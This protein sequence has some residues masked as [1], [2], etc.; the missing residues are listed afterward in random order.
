MGRWKERVAVNITCQCATAGEEV[1][2][3]NPLCQSQL[4][5]H[6]SAPRLTRADTKKWLRST[7]LAS[8][9][10]RFTSAPSST[11]EWHL[12]YHAPACH[13]INCRAAECKL[14]STKSWTGVVRTT[15]ASMVWRQPF[16]LHPFRKYVP[17]PHRD[18]FSVNMS[19]DLQDG[20]WCKTSVNSSTEPSKDESS[21]VAVRWS[22]T[23]CAKASKVSSTN[24]SCLKA[25]IA[26]GGV[27]WGVVL[28]PTSIQAFQTAT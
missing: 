8:V 24:K 26:G 19:T 7:Q 6:L 10:Q 12:I 4:R 17:T 16:F 13:T 25:P 14:R 2:L 23:P 27:G 20:S 18:S 11:T 22:T 9:P 1:C 28:D 21:T 3:R 5:V 15:M